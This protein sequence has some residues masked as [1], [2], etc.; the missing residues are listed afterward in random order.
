MSKPVDITGN[1]YGKLIALRP[2][3]EYSSASRKWVFLCDCG[4]EYIARK[5]H[6]TSGEMTHCI[7]CQK[8]DAR[9]KAT[10]HGLTKDATGK[11][12]QAWMNIKKRCHDPYD[13]SYKDYGSKGIKLQDSWV[14][15]PKLFVEYLGKAPS[16]EHSV[17]R[18]DRL[19]GYEEGNIR[20]ALP[21]T[22][23]RNRGTRR[24]LPTCVSLYENCYVFAKDLFGKRCTKRFKFYDEDSKE[25]SE[26][27][28]IEYRNLIFE[29]LNK[30]LPEDERYSDTHG[31]PDKDLGVRH[32]QYYEIC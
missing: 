16:S 10:V 23:S 8:E 9:K 19:K 17:E 27:V 31:L 13:A 20:W 24:S 7:T 29:K 6:I 2:T 25:L 22:Q 15:N 30:L 26:L 32:E 12:F 14:D 4:E 3:E 1:K 21:T 5:S 11:V 18:I 28:C